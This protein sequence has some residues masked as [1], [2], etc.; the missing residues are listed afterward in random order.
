MRDNI[1]PI[2]SQEIAMDKR[3]HFQAAVDEWKRDAEMKMNGVTNISRSDVM[4]E[5]SRMKAVG[6]RPQTEK[7]A[8]IMDH[9]LEL[10]DEY[11]RRRERRIMQVH[12]LI[13]PDESVEV[14]CSDKLGFAGI[15]QGTAPFNSLAD[16]PTSIQQHVAMLRMMEDRAFIP[17]VGTKIDA[18]NYWVEVFPE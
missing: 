2:S 18:N 8:H 17:E 14:Y 13:N 5:I 15:N 10:W 9:G 6:Y 11:R 4:T 3:I 7:F 1:K 12:V 16:T